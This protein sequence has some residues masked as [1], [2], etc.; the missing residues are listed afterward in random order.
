MLNNETQKILAEKGLGEYR[1]MRDVDGPGHGN[2]AIIEREE[3]PKEGGIL[4]HLI[5]YKYPYKGMPEEASVERYRIVK[6][7]FY[8]LMTMER[9]K[10]L[11]ATAGLLYITPRFIT[12]YIFNAIA[13]YFSTFI[14]W[15]T[16]WHILKAER[17]CVSVREVYRVMTKMIENEKDQSMKKLLDTAR[18][19]VCMFIEQDSAYRFRFQDIMGAAD[20]DKLKKG[21]SIMAK[22]IERLVQL[23]KDRELL[24]MYANLK[25]GNL[26]KILKPILMVRE[27]RHYLQEFFK[28]VDFNKLT[29]DE[30]DLYYILMRL[31]YEFLGKPLAERIEQRKAMDLENWNRY[32]YEELARGFLKEYN[33]HKQL[34]GGGNQCQ[35]Q[36]LNSS[37]IFK[38]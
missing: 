37:L 3:R 31:D 16:Y 25:W 4:V 1:M 23:M 6:K 8:F 20:R 27:V 11:M 12:K 5:G 19:I 13:D 36:S 33:I 15:L 21:G 34:E 26:Q 7:I 30:G 9:S 38:H 14:Y 10:G 18:N 35:K 24:P 28:E 17:Y 22:E 32:N 2:S 29:F